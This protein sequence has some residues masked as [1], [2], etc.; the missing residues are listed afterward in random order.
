MYEALKRVVAMWHIALFNFN[1]CELNSLNY[2]PKSSHETDPLII[3][4][5]SYET[6]KK[7]AIDIVQ[8][9]PS[10]TVIDALM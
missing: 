5:G 7:T 8:L 10:L 9:G 1:L 2:Y 3:S 6:G 4:H